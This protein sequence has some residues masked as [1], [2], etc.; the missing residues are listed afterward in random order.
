MHSRGR[1]PCDDQ[2]ACSDFTF[3][4]ESI[5]ADVGYATAF[6]TRCSVDACD[7]FYQGFDCEF[8]FSYSA[9]VGIVIGDAGKRSLGRNV[10]GALQ[11][12]PDLIVISIFLPS[13]HL[14]VTV[15][16]GP[17]TK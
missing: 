11:D 10:N 2:V 15:A 17:A 6:R 14:I 8:C 13:G 3:G 16:G 9:S 12:F 7:V 1:L 5:E 4:G